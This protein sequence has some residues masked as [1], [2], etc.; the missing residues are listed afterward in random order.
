[1]AETDNSFGRKIMGFF[2]K[3]EPGTPTTAPQTTVP[4][5]KAITS[6][7]PPETA[8]PHITP[9]TT[10]TASAGNLAGNID[11]KFVAHFAEVLEKANIEGP[12]YFE[13]RETLKSLASLGLD[14][15]K[16]YQAAWATFK[17]MT[18]QANTNFLTST[19]S[20][21]LTTL[22]A[23]REQFLKSVEAAMSERIGG[24]QR[25]QTQLQADNETLQKQIADLQ[26]RLTAN[27]DRLSKLG[28]EMTEQT[29]KLTQNKQNFEA[30]YANF[31]DQIKQDVS[32]IQ[33]Y[34]K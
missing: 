5:G 30:T 17:A 12:D 7:Q 10:E 3:D 1:M 11:T 29:Q 9:R 2:I 15:S 16:Q 6:A 22:N 24:L 25:E 20:Q 32:N 19:A 31:T 28:G 4:P 8:L 27:T 14:Q 34:L 21:Y 18:G 26:K 23:D 13:F 33:T